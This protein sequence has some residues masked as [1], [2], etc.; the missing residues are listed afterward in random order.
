MA[1][2]EVPVNH[3]SMMADKEPTSKSVACV[4][5]NKDGTFYRLF[6][7]LVND[8]FEALHLSGKGVDVINKRPDV[9]HRLD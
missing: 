3:G 9:N 6:L 4:F 2:P 5:S 7:D 1:L 8:D